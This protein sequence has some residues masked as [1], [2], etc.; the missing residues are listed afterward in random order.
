MNCVCSLYTYG[1]ISHLN[2]EPCAKASTGGSASTIAIILPH[3]WD[4]ILGHGLP[5][6]LVYL[7]LPAQFPCDLLSYWSI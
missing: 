3:M 1:Y 2:L 7:S 5:C 6:V 4:I